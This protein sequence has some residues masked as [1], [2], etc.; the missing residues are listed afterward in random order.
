MS[1]TNSFKALSAALIFAFFSLAANA[2]NTKDL[3]KIALKKQAPKNVVSLLNNLPYNQ[4]PLPKTVLYAKFDLNNDKR[5]EYFLL[6]YDA[7]WCGAS[8]CPIFIFQI[9]GKH[10]KILLEANSDPEIHI[11]RHK[12]KGYHDIAFYP[13]T[14]T[15]RYIWHWNGKQY[16]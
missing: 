4:E 15:Y 13:E 3:L 6:A 1:H 2:E 8:Y 10:K 9:K 12:T 5:K 11:L 14:E 16:K 7:S